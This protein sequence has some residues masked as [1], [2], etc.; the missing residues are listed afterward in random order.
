LVD[1]AGFSG[2][3]HGEG[4][5][6]QSGGDDDGNDEDEH[7][8]DDDHDQQQQQQQ[9]D[10]EQY[11][12]GG[13]DLPEAAEI[14]LPLEESPYAHAAAPL[15]YRPE[16]RTETRSDF[17]LSLRSLTVRM[18]TLLVFETRAQDVTRP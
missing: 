15:F 18:D 17:V 9:S 16:M 14:L 8:D 6:P 4:E 11:E 3:N 13:E 5:G 12:D 10:D 2:A 1:A 7:D